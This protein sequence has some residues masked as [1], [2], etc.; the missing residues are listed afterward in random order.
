MDNLHKN[1][2]PTHETKI[3]K[4][5]HTPVTLIDNPNKFKQYF[6]I[7]TA[8]S[9]DDKLDLFFFLVKQKFKKKTKNK[10]RE[11]LSKHIFRYTYSN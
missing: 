2:F 6:D 9:F 4:K 10:K 5:Y 8:I 11:V 1:F 3:N 7:L